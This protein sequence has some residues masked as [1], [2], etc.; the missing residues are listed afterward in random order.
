MKAMMH[1][2][3]ESGGN[4]ICIKCGYKEPHEPGIPCRNKTCPK[5]KTKLFREGSYHHRLIE[6]KRKG[7]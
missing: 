7:G 6:E 5:C 3:T 4:C 2:E 1:K